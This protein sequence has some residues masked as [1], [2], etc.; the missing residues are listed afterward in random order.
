MIYLKIWLSK[1]HHNCKERL[2]RFIGERN[3]FVGKYWC[4]WLRLAVHPSFIMCA[5]VRTTPDVR[6]AAAVQINYS[7]LSMNSILLHSSEVWIGKHHSILFFPYDAAL[8]KMRRRGCAACIY[9]GWC[10]CR[11]GLNTALI[12][13]MKWHKFTGLLQMCTLVDALWKWTIRLFLLMLF[14]GVIR[15]NIQLLKC[16]MIRKSV[17]HLRRAL[18]DFTWFNLNKDPLYL[19]SHLYAIGRWELH[20]LRCGKDVDFLL[21]ANA[22]V[23]VALFLA[24]LWH[25]PFW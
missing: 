23:V 3:A 8:H 11:A 19:L 14:D 16:L 15:S 17:A 2:I 18:W 9:R 5:G 25:F 7:T 6:G 24:C 13:L 4:K 22:C 20:H 10:C 1:S 12:S 21:C